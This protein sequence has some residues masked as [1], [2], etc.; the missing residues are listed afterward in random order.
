MRRPLAFT[1]AKEVGT[2]IAGAAEGAGVPGLDALRPRTPLG[3]P[4]RLRIESLDESGAF[5]V[6]GTTEEPGV[7]AGSVPGSDYRVVLRL[8]ASVVLVLESAPVV[9]GATVDPWWYRDADGDRYG[10]GATR[11]RAAAPPAGHVANGIDCDD[12]NPNRNPGAPEVEGNAIDDDCD[13]I[14][15]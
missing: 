8:G 13:G 5:E 1:F 11:T 14:A 2:W 9:T 15:K 6:L 12:A 7:P 10:D 3:P 4:G